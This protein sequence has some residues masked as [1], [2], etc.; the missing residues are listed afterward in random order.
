MVSD[1]GSSYV[2]ILWLKLCSNTLAQ[3]MKQYFGSSYVAMLWL[4]LCS[5]TLAQVMKQYFGSSYVAMFWLKLC[6]NTLA[7]VMKQYF[8]SSYV[9]MLWLKLCSNTLAQVMK[10]YFGSSYVA[11]LWLK[12]CSNTL[13]QVMKQYFGSSYVAMLWLKL[14]SN[15]LTQVMKQYFGSSYVAMLWLKL[16]SNTLAQVM[17]QY[18]GSSYVAMFWLKLKPCTDSEFATPSPTRT[19]KVPGLDEFCKR[20]P[21]QFHGGFAP[22]VALE[23]IL[24][25]DRI[26]RAMNYSE[27][28]K[29]AYA[30]YML[31]K[32]A[33]NW[34]EFTR[35]QMETKG[36]LISWGTFKEKFLHKYFPADLKRKKEMEFLKLEQGNMSVGEYAAKFEELARFC[37][38]SELEVDGRSKCSKFESGLRPELKIMFGHQEI[39]DFA[40]LVNKCRMYEGNLKSVKLATPETISPRDYG[41]QR[42]HM[43][44]RGKGKVEDDWKPY[45]AT[46]RDRDRSFQRSRPPTVPTG[47]VST[48][49]CNR[50]CPKLDRRPNVMHA[51]EA[52]DHGRMVTP[53]GVGTSGVDDPARG[54]SHGNSCTHQPSVSVVDVDVVS[55]YTVGVNG[56][57]FTIVLI[58]AMMSQ[59]D[60]ILE[61]D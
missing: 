6:S 22:D 10:Q 23:W 29:L 41:P 48:P 59:L 13:A 4:K 40:T 49:M 9:T 61:M 19:G 44:E 31:V 17:K 53:S 36:Q 1:F 42:N 39:A 14:C 35:R 52:R 16:C 60:L 47:G 8:G 25:M 24:G 20:N 55:Q 5:N 54:K 57:T 43:R 46:T 56:K 30:T 7:Q 45:A 51:E 18:F 50:F 27:A 15:T 3:V 33:E 11:M 58:C 28:Q 38:Y 34:W 2:A 21:S 26:F 32:E 37:P 12:L